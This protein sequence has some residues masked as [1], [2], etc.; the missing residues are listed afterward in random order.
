MENSPQ[1]EE[2]NSRITELTELDKLR[3]M[4]K[5]RREYQLKYYKEHRAELLEKQKVIRQ[6]NK[7][8]YREYMQNYKLNHPEQFEKVR[9]N[10]CGKDYI[11]FQRTQ[12]NITKIHLNT[13][14][15]T[16]I[17]DSHKLE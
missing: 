12:H 1:I 14:E 9:C 10:I 7:D 2:I 6:N 3:S 13:L 17:K 15:A 4:L 11:P 5:K 8:K 16:Q